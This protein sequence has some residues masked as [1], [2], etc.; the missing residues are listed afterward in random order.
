LGLQEQRF[1]FFVSKPF[2]QKIDLPTNMGEA[3]KALSEAEEICA[4]LEILKRQNY[5][6]ENPSSWAQDFLDDYL[7]RIGVGIGNAVRA[8]HQ[9]DDLLV[10][11]WPGYQDPKKRAVRVTAGR[12]R[13][14]GVG[15]GNQSPKATAPDRIWDD[16]L[17]A[18]FFNQFLRNKIP[19]IEPGG[20]HSWLLTGQRQTSPD[21]LAVELCS[22][23]LSDGT[24]GAS[25]TD[26]LSDTGIVIS[27]SESDK[28][29]WA[30][31]IRD[32]LAKIADENGIYPEIEKWPKSPKDSKPSDDVLRLKWYE[33]WL[34]SFL[35]PDESSIKDAIDD[36]IDYVKGLIK[37]NQDD[38]EKYL[39]Y[40]FNTESF[41]DYILGS[42][43][44]VEDIRHRF[45][46]WYSLRVVRPVPPFVIKT[47]DDDTL[48][49]GRDNDGRALGTVMLLTSK[50]VDLACVQMV[51]TWT[52]I[53]YMQILETFEEL[54]EAQIGLQHVKFRLWPAKAYGY[55]AT[56][57]YTRMHVRKIFD[58][59]YHLAHNNEKAIAEIRSYIADLLQIRRPELPAN[60]RPI[61]DGLKGLVGETSIAHHGALTSEDL[62]AMTDTWAPEGSWPINIGTLVILIGAATWRK[63]TWFSAMEWPSIGIY[64]KWGLIG[65][66]LSHSM[67]AAL[68]L[69]VCQEGGVFDLLALNSDEKKDGIEKVVIMETIL[70]VH[71]SWR[72]SDVLLEE[73]QG[74]SADTPAPTVGA[75][76]IAVHKLVSAM[77]GNRGKLTFANDSVTNCG[78]VTIESV[79][80]APKK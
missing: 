4:S 54:R 7:N 15:T 62:P 58:H 74:I 79:K 63:N 36:I 72:F 9:D 78:V 47:A 21:F 44:R 51:G 49:V 70:N 73:L 25:I 8:W 60:F 76:R 24:Q 27:L 68:V 30:S 20:T 2:E 57:N 66:G 75:L 59:E 28:G 50:P 16:D 6:L 34:T 1:G 13:D 33:A 71:L 31:K 18:K 69:T 10:Y 14:F 53:M 12:L 38:N 29:S 61:F 77:N 11:F 48:T 46:S 65:T 23:A 39:V 64:K 37:E 55:F 43:R 40:L 67:Q 5:D 22:A 56:A 3:W 26:V 19:G 45:S 35:S 41:K 17:N 52:R 80:M 42:R 32:S